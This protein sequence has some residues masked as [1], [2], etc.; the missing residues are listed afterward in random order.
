MSPTITW[1]ESMVTFLNI[2]YPDTHMTP[3]LKHPTTR[4][5][6]RQMEQFMGFIIGLPPVTATE[7][8]CSQKDSL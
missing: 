7:T 8:C 1:V 6:T 4:Q 3:A 2:D 5:A